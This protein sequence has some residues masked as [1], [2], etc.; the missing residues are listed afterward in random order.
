MFR[1][2]V[3]ML[4]LSVSG[5]STRTVYVPDGEPVRL[6]QT[7]KNVRVWTMDK[8]GGMVPGVVDISEGWY[9][10]PDPGEEKAGKQDV[11]LHRIGDHHAHQ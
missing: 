1:F 8:H 3:V 11:S 6:R 9:A 4:L 7:V 10:L 2:V 5:C